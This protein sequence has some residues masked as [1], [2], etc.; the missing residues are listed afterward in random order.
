MRD[1]RIFEKFNI[2]LHNKIFKPCMMDPILNQ[3]VLVWDSTFKNNLKFSSVTN[4]V[5][6]NKRL[7]NRKTTKEN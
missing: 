5:Y 3:S 2:S 7:K 4:K 6:Y 1:K